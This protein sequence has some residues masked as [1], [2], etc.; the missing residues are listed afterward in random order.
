VD[1]SI[2]HIFNFLYE[3]NSSISK[4]CRLQKIIF[5][6]ALASV[7]PEIGEMMEG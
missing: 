5:V 2:P 1:Q 6:A 3:Y 4:K 7:D